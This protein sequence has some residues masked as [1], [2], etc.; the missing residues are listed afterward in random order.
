VKSKN[1]IRV[2]NRHFINRRRICDESTSISNY[3][4]DCGEHF[5]LCRVNGRANYGWYAK[6]RDP[7]KGARPKCAEAG[8]DCRAEA[9]ECRRKA[10]NRPNAGRSGDIAVLR[11][12]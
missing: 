2:A 11:Q 3:F 10:P 6:K 5:D 7:G 12:L 9:F 8:P 4:I 1:W